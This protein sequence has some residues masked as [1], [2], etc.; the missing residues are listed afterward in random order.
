MFE[1]HFQWFEICCGFKNFLSCNYLFR[2][3]LRPYYLHLSKA[4]SFVL[5]HPV[6]L[7]RP[8]QIC[9]SR[10][11]QVHKSFPA[12]D[13][14]WA[15]VLYFWKLPEIHL[16]S[17]IQWCYYSD[18]KILILFSVHFGPKTVQ[19]RT[20]FHTQTQ[21][22]HS[23]LH[24]QIRQYIHLKFLKLLF[25]HWNKKLRNSVLQEVGEEISLS[26]VSKVTLLLQR[27]HHL[28]SMLICQFRNFSVYRIWKIVSFG[29]MNTT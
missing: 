3:L 20:H 24:Y 19:F 2:I 23:N 22:G 27:H 14:L 16:V 15:R 6:R 13:Q 29:A 25:V 9:S 7:V 11:N 5:V 28:Q 10:T 18:S 21:L 4:M 8:V 1:Y 17:H 26:V 12:V